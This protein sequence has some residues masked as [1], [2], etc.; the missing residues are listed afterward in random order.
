MKTKI[1][2]I[3]NRIVTPD[4]KSE[5]VGLVNK[6]IQNN[7]IEEMIE[8]SPILEQKINNLIENN[9]KITSFE[10]K[11]LINYKKE[12]RDN[13][14]VLKNNLERLQVLILLKKIEKS[15]D[16]SEIL[17]LLFITLNDQIENVNNILENNLKGGGNNMWRS[18]YIKYKTKYLD[19]YYKNL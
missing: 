13:F 2:D 18:K 8:V 3:I 5:L 6:K 14:S 9:S 16:N 1:I 7:E 15:V 17:N 19:L 11:K 4:I 12:T 10:N